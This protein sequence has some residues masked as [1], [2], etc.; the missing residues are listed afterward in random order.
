MLWENWQNTP[1]DSL[2]FSGDIFYD[3]GF[4]HLPILRKALK[5]STKRSVPYDQQQPSMQKNHTSID[6]PPPSSLSSSSGPSERLSPGLSSA[7]SAQ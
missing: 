1:S 4:F 3:P 6:L 7:V 2:I 5:P